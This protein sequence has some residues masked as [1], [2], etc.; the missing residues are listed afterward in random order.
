MVFG[1]LYGLKKLLLNVLYLVR[2]NP[3]IP[4]CPIRSSPCVE[5]IQ[6][7]IARVTA[8]INLIENVI[9]ASTYTWILT[10]NLWIRRLAFFQSAIT[11]L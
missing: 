1:P 5:M 2:K 6:G 9:D 7:A 10:Q 8:H 4:S 3:V 11:L